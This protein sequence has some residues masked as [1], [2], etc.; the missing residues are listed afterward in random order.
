MVVAGSSARHLD[1]VRSSLQDE[2]FQ[3]V[4]SS[5]SVIHGEAIPKHHTLV[6]GESVG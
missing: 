1:C 4:L 6:A 2:D 3:R 5:S